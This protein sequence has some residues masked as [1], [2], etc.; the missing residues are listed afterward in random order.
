M[1]QYSSLQFVESAGAVLFKLS[2][3]QICLVHHKSSNK[4][5]LPKGRRNIGENRHDAAVREVEEETGFK[6][7]LLP[8]TLHSFQPPADDDGSYIASAKKYEGVCE[9]FMLTHRMLGS[10]NFK[11]VWWYVAALAEDAAQG[12]GEGQF[13]AKFIAFEEAVRLLTYQADREVAEKA[14]ELLRETMNDAS[15]IGTAS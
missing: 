3:Q 15:K 12:T 7:R 6:G 9:P 11:I 1:A 14:I 5:L 2:T 8:V 10:G 4:W 13:D